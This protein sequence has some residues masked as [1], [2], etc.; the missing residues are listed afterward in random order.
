MG[1]PVDSLNDQLIQPDAG[2][3]NP[4]TGKPYGADFPTITTGDQVEAQ[5]RLVDHLGI[6]QLLAAPRSPWQRAYVEWVIGTMPR[7]CLV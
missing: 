6:K 4:A 3:A 7:E 5:R 2:S 1:Q